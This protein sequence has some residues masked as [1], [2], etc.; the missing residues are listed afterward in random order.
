MEQVLVVNN[1]QERLDENGQQEFCFALC[2]LI[3]HREDCNEKLSLV[4]VVV[5]NSKRLSHDD[6]CI[7][8][9]TRD[10]MLIH[11]NLFI[12]MKIIAIRK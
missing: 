10:N 12:T 5:V 8:M 3:S 11:Y 2:S 7:Y 6:K 1:K 9:S 4:K